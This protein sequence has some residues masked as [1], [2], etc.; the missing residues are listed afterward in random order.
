MLV[1]CDTILFMPMLAKLRNDLKN[2]A[3][4][5]KARILQRF[6]KTG[7]GEYGEGD[8]FLGITVP[9]SRKIA[10]RYKDLPLTDIKKLLQSKI[11]EERL[12]ALL[13]LVHNFTKGDEKK[14]KE[15]FDYYLLHTKYINNWDLVDLTADKIVGTYLLDKLPLSLRD[16]EQSGTRLPRRS[17]LT[18]R[19]DILKR[20]AKSDNL[21]ERRIAI[22]ATY[23]FIKEKKEYKDT[24]AVAEILLHD[25]HD[26]I[27]KA[28][29]WMLREVG[30]RVSQD[31]EESFLQKHYREMPRTMLRYAIEHF[32]KEQ[33]SAYLQGMVQY[34]HA[35]YC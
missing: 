16:I 9:D 29:G 26:L 10:I 14:R 30:K 24:F 4:P 32:S 31:V 17:F 19:N 8:V 15:I 5:A 18:P 23:Q 12:I 2:L 21:W 7:K 20:L 6:F 11:H 3:N 27:Q 35:Y 1:V 28:V 33:Q 34:R 22:I 25:K 13:I